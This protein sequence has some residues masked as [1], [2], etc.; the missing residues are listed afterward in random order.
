[1]QVMNQGEIRM[2][3]VRLA[4]PSDLPGGLSAMRSD[5][6]GHC[7]IFTIIDIREGAIAA[8]HEMVNSGHAPGGCMAPVA[9]LRHRGVEAIV[10]GGIGARPL[11]GFSE[12]GIA[13]HYADRRNRQTVRHVAEGMIAGLFPIIR[14]DQVCGSHG[15]C[16]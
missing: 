11:Q 12:A 3:A 1:M 14:P 16:H 5:H 2:K 8:V 15:S 4:V 13:V 6:F 7:D 9:L 10:V